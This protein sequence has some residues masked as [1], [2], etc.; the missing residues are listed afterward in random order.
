[1]RPIVRFITNLSIAAGLLVLT[2]PRPADAEGSPYRG[3]ITMS[4]LRGAL[5]EREVP[6]LTTVPPVGGRDG[7]LTRLLRSLGTSRD[8][9]IHVRNP[10]T[11]HSSRRSTFLQ[12]TDESW[13]LEV[14][15]DGA[16]FR[17][18]GN[19]DDAIE[20][21]EEAGLG[22][23]DM[24]TLEKLGRSFL[25]ERLRK[26]V[27]LGPEE[28][29]VFLGTRFWREESATADE[30]MTSAPVATLALF[31]R[32]VG[33]TFVTGPGSKIAV[34]FSSRGEVVGF[35][36]DWP[37]YVVSSQLQAT[38]GI[39]AFLSR[40]ADYAISPIEQIE[41]NLSRFECGYV[42]VG[43]RRRGR[44]PVQTGCAALHVGPLPDGTTYASTEVIPLGVDVEAD[45]S[46]PV[47]GFVRDGRRWDDLC[48]AFPTACAEPPAED[49]P[50]G[51][52]PSS[53]P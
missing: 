27:R 23:L 26:F 36:V 30:S 19:I 1:M 2:L 47:T 42:D 52:V 6:L 20:R 22:P 39:D 12:S 11:P 17:Y 21:Q 25:T 45:P 14:L 3:S 35:D 33:G 29:L 50:E 15:G 10:G 4:S 48:A 8:R 16:A 51:Y 44:A 37:T 49:D 7:Q 40:M 34:W 28:A 53:R 9:R 32:E 38:L 41:R 43:A 46:W 24:A 18:R 5:E 31:G 13:Y